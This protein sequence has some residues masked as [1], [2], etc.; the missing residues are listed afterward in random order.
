[1]PND[2]KLINVSLLVNIF[3]SIVF[4]ALVGTGV[5]YLFKVLTPQTISVS[6]SS[7]SL[8]K[9]QI[10]SYSLTIEVSDADK[11]KAVQALTDRAKSVI[12]MIKDFGIPEADVETTSLNVYQRQDSV[13]RSGVTTYELGDWYAS[14]TI[15]TKLRDLSKSD[16][17]TALL[18]TVEKASMWGPNL[19]IDDQTIDE[20]ALLNAAIEDARSKATAIATGVGKKLG[21]VVMINEGSAQY[22]LGGVKYD[23][24]MGVGGGGGIPVEP[25]STSAYKNVT[26]M[27]ELR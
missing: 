24:G 16:D 22:M 10:A 12:Q 2:N 18:A 19:T 11:A 15:N 6:G 25:G 3:V 23:M 21:R 7:T 27:F 14:Y 13:Y 1:M 26:V 9:N 20:E 8:V 4:A 17:L 5:W